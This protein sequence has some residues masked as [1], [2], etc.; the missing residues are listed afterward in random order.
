MNHTSVDFKEQLTEHLR[1]LH[2]PTIRRCFEDRARHAE[3]ETLSYEWYLHEL[4]ELECQ[5]RRENRIARLLQASR[6]PLE[7]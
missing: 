5:E 6:L 3:R 2:L 4:A 1:E 7:K